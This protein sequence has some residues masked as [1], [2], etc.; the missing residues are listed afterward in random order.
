MKQITNDILLDI[1]NTVESYLCEPP[2]NWSE[3]NRAIRIYQIC[4]VEE[5]LKRIFKNSTDDPLDIIEG[6]MIETE[7]YICRKEAVGCDDLN[8]ILVFKTAYETAEDLLN[9][10]KKKGY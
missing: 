4:A 7:I 5:I 2:A 6:F 3:N 8:C 1:C 9:F 10:L